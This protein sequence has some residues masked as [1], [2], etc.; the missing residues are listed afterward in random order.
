MRL[1]MLEKELTLAKDVYEINGDLSL[2]STSP[3]VVVD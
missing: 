2:V 1:I 3:V